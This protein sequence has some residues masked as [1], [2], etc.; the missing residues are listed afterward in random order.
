[1]K[2]RGNYLW[3][4]KEN[5]VYTVSMTPELQDDV[6]TVGFFE[7]ADATEIKAGDPIAN[8][9]AA[10]TILEIQSPISGRII[11]RNEKAPQEP[12]ILNSAKA[13]DNWLIKL[14]DVNEDEFNGLEDE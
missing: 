5:D 1:M 10:K 9:E 7:F 8:I 2:K 13:E 3:V 11:E 6:G 4:T 12:A 14:T